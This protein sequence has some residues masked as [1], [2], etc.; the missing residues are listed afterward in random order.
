MSTLFIA[1]I[2]LG[3][4][5]PDI[6]QRFVKFLVRQAPSTEALYIL[7]DLFEVWLG[8]D[9]VQQ[10]HQDAIQVLRQL[11][12]GGLPIYVMHG[13]RDFLIGKG[14]EAMTGCQL[15]HDPLLIDLD[16]KPT[17]LMH[18]DSLCI[19]DKEYQQLRRQ[20][21][22]SEWQQQFLS[23]SIEQRLEIAR[24]YRDESRSRIQHKSQEIMDVNADAVIEAMRTHSVPQLIHGHTHRPAVHEFEID[25][26]PAQ[27]IVLGDWYSHNSS[28]LCDERGCQLSNLQ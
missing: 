1:D 22:S 15:I 23:A 5:N 18:G 4:E 13:N 7:G 19:D 11:T 24:Q 16:G 25:G 28:L 27:R 8:D 3:N 9:A 14:F 6:S 21:R 17:L 10:E 2:H 20:L 12:D 26:M